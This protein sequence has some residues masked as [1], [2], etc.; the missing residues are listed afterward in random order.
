MRDQ[1]KN[2]QK[3]T[4]REVL[5]PWPPNSTI[6]ILIYERIAANAFSPN[7]PHKC[8]KCKLLLYM[9]RH[10]K[11]TQVVIFGT[12]YTQ[13]F[14]SDSF[15]L[16]LH[17]FQLLKR[18]ITLSLLLYL[19]IMEPPPCLL[20]RS[21]ISTIFHIAIIIFRALLQAWRTK[22]IKLFC[23]DQIF[24]LLSALVYESIGQVLNNLV[25]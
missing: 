10:H 3:I 1:A 16:C 12:K 25:T 21:T 24:L 5:T 23:T 20:R 14:Q 4:R 6:R 18:L 19:I 17:A 22:I 13:A 15:F 8:Y 11:F 2:N 7:I 9:R